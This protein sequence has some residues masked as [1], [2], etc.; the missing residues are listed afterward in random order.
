MAGFDS[1][2]R[3]GQVTLHGWR[4]TVQL[5]KIIGMS[6]FLIVAG[7]VAWHGLKIKDEEPQTF[8]AALYYYSA[9]TIHSFRDDDY[10]ISYKDQNDNPKSIT[11]GAIRNTPGFKGS[12][13]WLE[14]TLINKLLIGAIIGGG[15]VFLMVVAF[16]FRGRN[17]MQTKRIKGAQL[18]SAKA[19]KRITKPGMFSREKPYSFVGIPWRRNEETLHTLIVG[20]TGSGK[21]V[22]ISDILDQINANGDKAIVYDKLG[23]FVPY[24]YQP[25][26]DII[27]NPLDE[28]SAEWCL[29]TEAQTE[30]D[31]TTMAA[32]IIPDFKDTADPFWFESGRLLFAAAMTSFWK[33]GNRDLKEVLKLLTQDDM[34]KLVNAM[35]GTTVQSI[36][37]DVESK[38][39]LS[40]RATLTRHLV[41]LLMLADVKTPF[42]VRQWVQDDNKSGF[43]FLTSEAASHQS[44][45]AMI[46]TQI[47][48][49]II[50][51]L[52]MMKGTNKRLWLILDELPTLSQIPS[53]SSG[54]RESRQ[55]GMS[56]VLGTQ[57]FSELKELY[58][59]DAATSLSGNCN[60]RLT[61]SSP[62][63]DTALWMSDNLGRDVTEQV[64]EGFSYGASE[65]R[66]GVTQSRR[67]VT[68]PIVLPSDIM[69]LAPLQGYLKMPRNLP[70]A[71]VKLE[72]KN[73]RVIAEAFMPFGH[74]APHDEKPD[75][76]KDESSTAPDEVIP[77]A[78]GSVQ[79]IDDDGNWKAASMQSG[80]VTT[81]DHYN[82]QSIEDYSN[83]YTVDNKTKP[84]DTDQG[85]LNFGGT[86]YPRSL[87][88]GQKNTQFLGERE[89]TKTTETT[90]N[91]ETY[92]SSDNAHS[93]EP[94]T[95]EATEN[96]ENLETYVSSDNAHSNEPKTTEATENTE[97]LETY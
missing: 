77:N 75:P 55:F 67:E 81:P 25:E 28:R 26:R 57:V 76:P 23:S 34:R 71:K 97:N 60:T 6:F 29:F 49:A 87:L 15:V 90:E 3:G 63:R 38:I 54:L 42:S 83:R 72:P 91:L 46:A 36:I 62:D 96:T 66:D 88:K 4:M 58:G 35:K 64:T 45:R 65:I 95:T 18:V 69:S 33:K 17:V 2:I 12:A 56:I 14:K 30:T 50:A 32:A 47:E 19:L 11:I 20:S 52:S 70:V 61:L 89:A 21:T 59:R 73:R 80:P 41:P 40:V 68:N 24:F 9:I 5:M 13:R 94:K 31:F 10:V 43:L 92:V 53:L 22:A 86:D 79:P 16:W 74:I 51:K 37:G 7:T 84:K 39:T 8:K 1:F 27:L 78:E 82:D 44:R 85:S 93:D 48:L